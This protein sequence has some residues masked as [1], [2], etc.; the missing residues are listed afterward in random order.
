VT[1]WRID[2]THARFRDLSAAVQAKYDC[3]QNQVHNNGSHP[4]DAADYCRCDGFEELSG[5]IWSVRLSQGD[6]VYFKLHEG[7]GTVEIVEVGGHHRS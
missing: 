4:R 7:T 3:F 5:G 2:K 6:R 1:H